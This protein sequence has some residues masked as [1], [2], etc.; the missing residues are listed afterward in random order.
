M[1][2]PVGQSCNLETGLERCYSASA[3]YSAFFTLKFEYFIH[4][5]FAGT[6]VDSLRLERLDLAPVENYKFAFSSRNTG[7]SPRPRGSTF[8]AICHL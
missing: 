6:A 3:S 4:F 2:A 1:N 7:P 5:Y 8:S